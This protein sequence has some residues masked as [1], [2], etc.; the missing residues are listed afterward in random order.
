MTEP[1]IHH[2]I[3]GLK[4]DVA[5]LR[6]EVRVTKHDVANVAAAQS[7]L[8]SR[9]DRMEE[10]IGNKIEGLAEK[11]G[12]VNT[13][14]ARGLGFFAGMAFVVTAAGGLLLALGKLLFTGHP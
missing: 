7:G 6:A 2:E 10:R 13:Q 9:L 12:V 8:G 4:T 5:N 11:I 1:D 3:L 14:Q